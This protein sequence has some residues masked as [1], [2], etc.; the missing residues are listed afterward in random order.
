M[1]AGSQVSTPPFGLLLIVGG[2]YFGHLM[3]HGTFPTIP[4]LHA[5]TGAI[6]HLLARPLLMD[7]LLGGPV[8]GVLT[9][10]AAFLLANRFY[11]GIEDD[12]QVE[13]V[14]S[15]IGPIRAPQEQSR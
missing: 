2:V 4:D 11:H 10:V 3:L 9:A 15:Q 14:E 8:L 1:L 5:T 13:Q 6:W 12:V 7:W